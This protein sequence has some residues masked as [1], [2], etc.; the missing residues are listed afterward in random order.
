MCQKIINREIGGNGRLGRMGG[1]VLGGSG[2][3]KWFLPCP[4]VLGCSWNVKF[5]FWGH[6]I[7]WE[8]FDSW[9]LGGNMVWGI[10]VW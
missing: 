10:G 8:L 1:I 4:G 2:K 7:G 6:V 3:E 5:F 9:G